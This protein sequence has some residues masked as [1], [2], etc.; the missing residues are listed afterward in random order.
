MTVFATHSLPQF[1][2]PAIKLALLV[3][4]IVGLNTAGS[5]LVSRTNFQIWPEHMLLVELFWLGL[6]LTYAVLMMLPFVPGIEI[7]LALMM[8]LGEQGIV[9]VY[10]ATQLAMA[11]S[12]ALGRLL[13]T[14]KLCT[15]LRSAGLRRM[16]DLMAQLHRVDMDERAQ[17]L[18][19]RVNHC[20]TRWIIGHPA[21][22]LTALVNVPGNAAIGGA[23][24]IALLTGVSGLFTWRR[25]LVTMAVATAPV[26][27]FLL[28]GGLLD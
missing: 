16:A 11:G 7:G 22:A 2:R 13:G 25:Y 3:T 12:F 1:T 28:A 5:W 17:W 24:G 10:L 15:V 19:V 20:A 8:M 18:A 21:L 9:L 23:G 14:G 6:L 27:V 26:P 4:L